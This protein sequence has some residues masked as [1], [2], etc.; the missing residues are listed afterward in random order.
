MLQAIPFLVGA[1]FMTIGSSFWMLLAARTVAG[2]GVGLASSLCNLYISEIVPDEH[3]GRFGA[4]APFTV[5]LGIL[6]SYILAWAA[7]QLPGDSGVK[8]RVMLG[9]SVVA[10]VAGLIMAPFCLVESPRWLLMQGDRI[11]ATEA[12]T[13]LVEPGPGVLKA[14]ADVIDRTEAALRQQDMEHALSVPSMGSGT[15][16]VLPETEDVST[17]LLSKVATRSPWRRLLSPQHTSGLVVGVGLNVLQQVCGINVVVYFAPT[18]LLRA[19]FSK[20]DSIL[21]TAGVGVAQLVAT[22]ALM[23][24][25]DKI[26]RRPLNFVG[27]IAMIASLA[28]M[29]TAFVHDVSQLAIAKWLAVGGMLVFRVAFSLSLGPLPCVCCCF[30]ARRAVWASIT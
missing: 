26:G 22:Y 5:T 9:V 4:W 11:R 21:L 28:L 14:V 23:R 8:W 1:T 24:L 6:V 20:T 12:L 30:L 3:R 16:R 25:V 7:A 13:S 2:L 10:P 27:L 17:A 29:A 19:G 15:L 18:V